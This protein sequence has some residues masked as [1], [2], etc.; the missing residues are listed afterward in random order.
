MSLGPSGAWGSQAPLPW[1]ERPKELEEAWNPELPQEATLESQVP[2]AGDVKPGQMVRPA[3]H[4]E[5][6]WDPAWGPVTPLDHHQAGCLPG[7]P[8]GV[9]LAKGQEHTEAPLFGLHQ[10]L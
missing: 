6:G 10:M 5:G 8:P 1:S 7:L 2:E 9:P 4:S 3:C